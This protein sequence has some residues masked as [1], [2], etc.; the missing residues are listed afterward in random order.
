[1]A[2]LSISGSQSSAVITIRHSFY[3]RTTYGG[4][5]TTITSSTP[6]IDF[7]AFF[8]SEKGVSESTQYIECKG[9]YK[10]VGF[11]VCQTDC[12]IFSKEDFTTKYGDVLGKCLFEIDRER[13]AIERIVY[14]ILSLLAFPFCTWGIL[15]SLDF[16]RVNPMFAAI[17]VALIVAAVF[18][19]S[20]RL[21][22]KIFGSRCLDTSTNIMVFK[23][24]LR[25]AECDLHQIAH[26]TPVT[27]IKE[28]KFLK[29]KTHSS[30][31]PHSLE[32]EEINSF[33][34][35]DKELAE[36]LNSRHVSD[37]FVRG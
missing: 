36:A 33:K 5:P 20:P 11:I 2:K 34:F 1:M 24:E 21:M 31:G 22:T 14:L 26:K 16:S 37:C 19:L 12:Y 35:S 3:E 30:D 29:I 10:K 13:R 9:C 32:G 27:M 17:I 25:S 7:N 15:S 18:Y 4:T 23:N 28:I 8:H 6:I